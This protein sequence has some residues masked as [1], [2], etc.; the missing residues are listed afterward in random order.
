MPY[1]TV[2][3]DID[4]ETLNKKLSVSLGAKSGNPPNKPFVMT[5]REIVQNALAILA[6]IAFDTLTNWTFISH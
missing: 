1:T 3:S 6:S 4:E 2:S 5:I